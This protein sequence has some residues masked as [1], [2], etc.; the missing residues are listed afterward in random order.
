MQ[1]A[2]YL[3]GKKISLNQ[4]DVLGVG[5]EA[6]VVQVGTQAIKLF[7]TPT[8]ER[9]AKLVEFLQLGV[10][11]KTVC[12]PIALVHDAKG[13]V[14]G[15]AMQRLSSQYE[16]VQKLASK[17][18][19]ASHPSLTAALV[20]D[21]F[22]NAHETTRTLHKAGLVVGDYNDL[23]ALFWKARMVFIDADSFQFGKHPCMVGTENFLDPMLYNL[24]LAKKP[25]FQPANDWYSWLVMYIRSLIM[26][27]PFG[28][29]HRKLKTI[30]DRTEAKVT[31]FSPDV[32]YPK[33]GLHP[34]LL[35]DGLRQMFESM[36][37]KGE[38]FVPSVEVLEEYRDSLVQCNSCSAMY[39]SSRAA[40]P[41]CAKINTQQVQRRVQVVKKPGHRTVNSERML[42]TSG[43]F[44]WRHLAGHSIYA[45]AVEGSNFVL[46]CYE[47]N[48]PSRSME[49]LPAAG[50]P[51][52]GFFAGK[53]LVVNDGLQD[54]LTVWDV[55][56][57]KPV[58]VQSLAVDSFQGTRAFS[59]TKNYLFRIRQG[60]LFRY[61]GS[62]DKSLKAV[63]RDQTWIHGSSHGDLIFGFQRFFE[64]LRFFTFR[65]DR[66]PQGEFWYPA[67]ATKLQDNESII[68]MSLRFAGST[69]LLLV[70]TEIKGK[71]FT[72]CFVIREDE[73]QAYY[74]VDALSS[75]T[76]RNIH[77]KAFAL[78][79]GTVI[80]LHPTDDGVVQEIIDAKSNSQLTL[81][82][83]TEQF[84]SE[85]DT[86]DQ[87]RS[88]I[89]VTGD[90]M[91][92]YLTI[93]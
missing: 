44:V 31:F 5:G 46:H 13:K 40:C 18:Y 14:I 25:Y 88:G 86:I 76:L 35:D 12:A 4:S 78:A 49:I 23:N 26:V 83:E 22:L 89:L 37:E 32:K 54:Y 58:K 68:D 29:V 27:H 77:G 79:A 67:V 24:D 75:D 19:R 30:P 16:V 48:K 15:F 3:S 91:I 63:A 8:P 92:N 93:V 69:I 57:T 60:F 38:R 84:V 28:G 21:L 41:Q 80:V 1:K 11:P 90:K 47:P 59:C 71:T 7:H 73:L 87:Y 34:D 85:S 53:Y 20:T 9:E 65:Y 45:V 61:D 17:K 56:G 70:K 42:E 10:L 66:Q 64:T 2:I 52:F 51:R 62:Q 6:T 81:L 55:S 33:A 36:F 39:P 50:H 72:H 43:N 82:S 74:R